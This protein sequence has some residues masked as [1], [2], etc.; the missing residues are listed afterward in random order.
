MEFG[1]RHANLL[2]GH[3]GKAR[4]VKLMCDRDGFGRAVA[5]LGKDQVGLA[6]A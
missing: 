5:V 6:A 4:Q 2:L 1:N 3:V